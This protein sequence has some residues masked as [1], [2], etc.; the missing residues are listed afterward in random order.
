VEEEKQSGGG[1]KILIGCCG[2]LL[3]L[4]VLCVGGGWYGLN[5]AKDGAAGIMRSEMADVLAKT[6]LSTEQ[7]EGIDGEIERFEIAVRSWSLTETAKHMANVALLPD[8]LVNMTIHVALVGYSNFV[9]P[10][11]DLPEEERELGKRTIQRYARGIDEG[12]IQGGQSDRNSWELNTKQEHG[13]KVEFNVDEVR[14]LL[15]DLQQAAEAAQVPD[16]PYEVDLTLK[17]KGIVDTV[18]SDPGE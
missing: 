2:G 9:L 12:T 5:K 18:L 3:L 8:E 17:L 7:I 13:E 14:A 6:E 10:N 15:A 4:A 16:E 11:T 1:K